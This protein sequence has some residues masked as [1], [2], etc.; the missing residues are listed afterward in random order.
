MQDSN[1]Q[2]NRHGGYLIAIRTAAVMMLL[3]AKIVSGSEDNMDFVAFVAF[4]YIL[5]PLYVDIAK[6]WANHKSKKQTNDAGH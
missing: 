2:Q 5:D 1:E 6:E 3:L 4:L